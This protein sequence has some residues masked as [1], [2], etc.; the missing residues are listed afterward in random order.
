MELTSRQQEILE[1]SLTV[2]DRDGL[3]KF[4]MKNV[5]QEIGV[6]DA[7]LY[8]HFPDKGAI[9]GALATLFKESTLDIL[10]EIRANPGV[11]ALGKL[12]LFIKGRARQFQDNR[13]LTV[14][15]FSEELFRGVASVNSLNSDTMESHAELLMDIVKEGQV[16]GSVRPDLPAQHLV[17]LLTGPMRLM[18]TAWK[19]SPE[20]GPTLVQRV[21][22][23]WKTYQSIAQ[24]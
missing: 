8:K 1:A 21:D 22:G 23:F 11:S 2:I 9:L 18:V 24:G 15:L 5:A 13:A 17:L 12:E 20:G 16:S 10:A 7:A 4:T 6:T 3:K 19:T 14:T